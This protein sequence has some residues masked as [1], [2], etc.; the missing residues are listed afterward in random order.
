MALKNLLYCVDD[1]VAV[2]TF[3]RP[4]ALNALNAE[5]LEEF[6]Q[7]LQKADYDDNVGALVLTGSGH[8]AFVVG[9][10]IEEIRT[11]TPSEAMKYTEL[12]NGTCRYLEKLAKPSVAAVNGIALG[13]GKEIAMSCDIRFSSENAM[14]GQPEILLGII[15]GWGG[16]QRLPRLIGQGRALELLLSG[17]QITA[18]RAYEIGLVNRI[19]PEE[20]LLENAVKFARKLAC[21][22]PFAMKMLKQA[23]YTGNEIDMASALD[24]EIQCVSQCFSTRDQK[25]GMAAFREKRSPVWTGE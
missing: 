20:N 7:T 19:F 21:M 10:D 18:Q 16:S 8:K 6:R 24:F 15:P 13:G 2:I 17:E 22:P 12:G 3:N 9:A 25:E 14:F 23:V 1:G 5:T 4:K 11:K